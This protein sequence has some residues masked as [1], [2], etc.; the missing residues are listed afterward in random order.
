MDA[1]RDATTA[2]KHHQKATEL[3][4]KFTDARLLLGAHD[5]LV[6]SLPWGYKLLGFL[7]GIRGDR[8]QGIA[9]LRIVAEQ[10]TMN[11]YDAKIVLAAIYR[12]E[13][14]ARE[15][16][17]LLHE[18]IA[19]FPRNYLFRLELAQMFADLGDKTQALAAI[20]QVEEMKRANSTGYASLPMEKNWYYRGNLLF[21]YNELD[22]ALEQ[23]TKVA[24]RADELDLNTGVMAWLRIGQIHDLKGRREQ[25]VDAYRRAIEV[26]PQSEAAKESR[27]YL[28]SAYNRV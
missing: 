11:R 18:L 9:T 17:P 21:W 6:G 26:A 28:R 15:A 3:D 13:R 14:R 22:P 12:R 2:R 1:L 5:Y 25:A 7:A 19:R 27:Q 24:K 8:E 4:P 23:L 10:G 20:A 16:V